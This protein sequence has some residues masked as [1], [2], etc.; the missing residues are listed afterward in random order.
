MAEGVR[1]LQ[2][3]EVI[4]GRIFWKAIW[5]TGRDT[6]GIQHPQLGLSQ[7]SGCLVKPALGTVHAL[8]LRLCGPAGLILG[9]EIRPSAQ[10]IVA[11][12]DHFDVRFGHEGEQG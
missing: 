6:E 7:I 5:V 8:I 3:A 10:W 9:I 12:A 1:A 2:A 4:G 11:N